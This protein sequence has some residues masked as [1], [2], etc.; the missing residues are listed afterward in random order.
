MKDTGKSGPGSMSRHW[1]RDEDA[2]PP[3][4]RFEKPGLD[5]VVVFY[6]RYNR[7]A[8]WAVQVAGG[9]GYR[10]CFSL[11]DGVCGWRIDPTVLAY[12]AFESWAPPPEPEQPGKRE[13]LDLENGLKELEIARLARAASAAPRPSSTGTPV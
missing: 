8:N 2:L 6:S 12:P 1:G 10:R 11:K 3:P 7:R 9:K 4:R 5:D 13:D